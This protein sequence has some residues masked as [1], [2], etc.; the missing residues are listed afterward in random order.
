MGRRS[1]ENPELSVVSSATR[2]VGHN[3]VLRASSVVMDSAFL[4]AATM[5]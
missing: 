4:F 5:G 2:A 1:A 3:I